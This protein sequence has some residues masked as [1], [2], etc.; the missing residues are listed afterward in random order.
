MARAYTAATAAV[1]LRVR[2]KWVDNVLSHHA[3]PG[4]MQRKQGVARRLTP[5][6]I[7]VLELARTISRGLG[8]PIGQAL[9]LAEELAAQGS[10]NASLRLQETISLTVDLDALRSAIAASISNAVEV[11]P[12]RR[13]GRPRTGV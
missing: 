5:Q 11:T 6:A 13:R 7:L 9:V 3:V 8:S 12:I 1:A 10:G 4:V 2:I